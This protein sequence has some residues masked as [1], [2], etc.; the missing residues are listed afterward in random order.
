MLAGFQN[1]FG[2]AFVAIVTERTV[3]LVG[4][5]FRETIDGVKRRAKF[6]AHGGEEYGFGLAGRP[7]WANHF[8][9]QFLP[10]SQVGVLYSQSPGSDGV[11]H[12]EDDVP[13]DD[14]MEITLDK[15]NLQRPYDEPFGA[16]EMAY[17]QLSAGDVSRKGISSRLSK[18]M[19][20]HID[21]AVNSA[22]AVAARKM[23]T[24]MSWDRKQLAYPRLIP[25]STGGGPGTDRQP[26]RAGVDDNKDG[27]I[28]N[29]L[30]LG[31]PGSDDGRAWEF[32]ADVDR[33]NRLEFPPAFTPGGVPAYLGY[34]EDFPDP[35][36]NPAGT[37]SPDPFRPQVRRLLETE[38]GNRTETRLQFRLSLNALTDVVRNRT[39]PGHPYYSSLDVRPLTAHSTDTSLTT[40]T[41]VPLTGAVPLF[42]PTTEADRE[43]WARF[44]RQYG[45]GYLRHSLHALWR[46]RS[47]D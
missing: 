23:F 19:P 12:T 29:L 37:Y 13:F 20:S 31:Y 8:G 40:V 2:V 41:Q 27:I 33:D 17:L 35:L 24:S 26:G 15:D 11:W 5:H 4:D 3:D 46:R 22:R 25:D 42:P 32:S 1:V 45:A 14:M 9:A 30:E 44:D 6:V 18:L 21:P 7:T 10:N 34:H 43:F 36:V 38:F 39:N 28:D 16:E 47:R